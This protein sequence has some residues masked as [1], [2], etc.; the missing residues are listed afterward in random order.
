MGRSLIKYQDEP[1]CNTN[2]AM[3]RLCSC[4]VQLK[5]GTDLAVSQPSLSSGDVATYVESD[6]WNGEHMTQLLK[7]DKHSSSRKDEAVRMSNVCRKGL[8]LTFPG[9]ACILRM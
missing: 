7:N 6:V 1:P 4:A 5:D 8:A 3:V 2:N 9:S